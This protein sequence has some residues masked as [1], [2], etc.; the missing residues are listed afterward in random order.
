MPLIITFLS[1]LIVCPDA[2]HLILFRL[3]AFPLCL[4][5]FDKPLKSTTLLCFDGHW[6]GG[7]FGSH[8]ST[9]VFR[10][11]PSSLQPRTHMQTHMHAQTQAHVIWSCFCICFTKLDCKS[12]IV[13][14]RMYVTLVIFCAVPCLKQIRRA[15]MEAAQPVDAL[16]ND[17]TR[18]AGMGPGPFLKA[19]FNHFRGRA[20]GFWNTPVLAVPIS[21]VILSSNNSIACPALTCHSFPHLVWSF[22]TVLC[23]WTFYDNGNVLYLHYL[24]Q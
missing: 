4:T 8:I 11:W 7:D 19:H 12:R 6:C 16:S 10:T 2:H 22:S 24:I 14:E 18:Y 15:K 20:G 23:N 9:S 1:H 5:I 13:I 17:Y 21:A 3:K